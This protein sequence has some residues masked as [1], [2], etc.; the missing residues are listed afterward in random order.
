[1]ATGTR[2]KANVQQIW[3]VFA[4]IGGDHAIVQQ[5]R[6]SGLFSG[7]CTAFFCMSW[8]LRFCLIRL[9]DA[10]MEK[11]KSVMRDL[12]GRYGTWE[13]T[14]GRRAARTETGERKKEDS[15]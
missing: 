5:I 6:R 15:R 9:L 12:C 13:P 11:K 14:A 3:P 4:E 2:C 1:M 8:P 7:K 10:T